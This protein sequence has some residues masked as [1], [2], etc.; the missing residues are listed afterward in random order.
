MSIRATVEGSDEEWRLISEA[1]I[2]AAIKH[3][4][5]QYI[6]WI[7]SLTDEPAKQWMLLKW[8]YGRDAMPLP[9]P[10]TTTLPQ[11]RPSRPSRTEGNGHHV[12]DEAVSDAH[13]ALVQMGVP[14]RGLREAVQRLAATNTRLDAA[15]LV[16]EFFRRRNAA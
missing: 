14:R 12:D 11:L 9:E 3:Q 13:D 2:R 15:G 1:E 10:L 6:Q 5:N 8:A 4:V 7:E 16:A